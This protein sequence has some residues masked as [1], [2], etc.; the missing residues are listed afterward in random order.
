MGGATIKGLSTV[1]GLA[2]LSPTYI[3]R[4]TPAFCPS[5]KRVRKNSRNHER[6]CKNNNIKFAVS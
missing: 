1:V 6:L 4:Y 5:K 2:L 3:A